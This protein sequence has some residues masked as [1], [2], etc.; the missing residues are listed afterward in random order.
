M[1]SSSATFR[2]IADPT[3][4]GILD[5]LAGR[6]L[7]VKEIV[8]AFS[9]SQPAV[10]KHLRILRDAGLVRERRVG[11]TRR[12]GIDPEPLGAVEEWIAGHRGPGA[13]TIPPRCGRGWRRNRRTSRIPR[14]E[15]PDGGLTRGGGA[16]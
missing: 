16:S 7:P 3:R 4:R 1:E 12:Y 11:R 9:V 6:E 13:P 15:S 5:L 10:S 2:A 14:G 8:A